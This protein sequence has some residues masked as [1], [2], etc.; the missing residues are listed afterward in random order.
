M[1]LSLLNRGGEIVDA[2]VIA[3]LAYAFWVLI[4]RFADPPNPARTSPAG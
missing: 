2:V 3:G 4:W 1:A